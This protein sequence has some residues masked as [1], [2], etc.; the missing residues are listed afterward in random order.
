MGGKRRLRQLARQ[1]VMKPGTWV[2]TVGLASGGKGELFG[3]V[4]TGDGTV[5]LEFRVRNGN[6]GAA[7]V[8]EW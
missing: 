7:S 1:K 4:P 2:V 3:H 6:C 5:V 8:H